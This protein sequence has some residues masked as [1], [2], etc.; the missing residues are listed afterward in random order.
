METKKPEKFSKYKGVHWDS[1][2]KKWRVQSNIGGKKTHLGYFSDQKIG[3]NAYM[4]HVK[5]FHNK[6]WKA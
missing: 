1:D 4:A 6:Q 5:E 3:S 2:N